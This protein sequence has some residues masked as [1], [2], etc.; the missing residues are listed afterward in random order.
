MAGIARLEAKIST[1]TPLGITGPLDLVEALA[2]TIDTGPLLVRVLT[3]VSAQAVRIIGTQGITTVTACLITSDQT[4]SISYNAGTAISL[5]AG[6]F[7]M[8]SNTSIT[9]M[10]IT[11]A[12]GNTANVT[13]WL[14]GS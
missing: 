6:G 2:V 7:H 5:V 9:A 14:V 3:G 10:A 12:S 8:F 4:I 11:N 1:T 13:M